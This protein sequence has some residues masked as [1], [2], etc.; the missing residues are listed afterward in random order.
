MD[1]NERLTVHNCWCGVEHAIP[2][3]LDRA[4]REEGVKV[5]CPLGH[6]WVI[7]KTETQKLREKLYAREAELN[8]ASLERDRLERKVRRL[9]KPKPKKKRSK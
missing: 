3:N 5:Y 4:A 7:T 8:E 6:T 2:D 1:A 9:E